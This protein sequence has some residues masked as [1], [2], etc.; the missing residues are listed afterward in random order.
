MLS[1]IKNCQGNGICCQG[2]DKMLS[3]QGKCC[4]GKENVVKARKMLSRQGKCC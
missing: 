3:R 4:Q 1:R 2:E